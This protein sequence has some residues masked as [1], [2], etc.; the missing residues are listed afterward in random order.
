M[1]FL[2]DEVFLFIMG[3]VAIYLLIKMI[4][5]ERKE[6]RMTGGKLFCR[7][8]W[9]VVESKSG[10][11]IKTEI[12]LQGTSLRYSGGTFPRYTKK[13][14]LKCGKK[15]D[16]LTPFRKRIIKEYEKEK[17]RKEKAKELW[18]KREGE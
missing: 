3:I 15:K 6:T 7:H 13:V 5:R 14:C 9:E 2:N 18:G 10:G 12:R 17:Q 11:D 16:T 4:V 8:D 1:E